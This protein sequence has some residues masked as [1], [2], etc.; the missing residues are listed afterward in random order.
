MYVSTVWLNIYVNGVFSEFASLIKE[1]HP[2]LIL[3]ELLIIET[4]F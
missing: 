3:K 4:Q 2:K 1:N